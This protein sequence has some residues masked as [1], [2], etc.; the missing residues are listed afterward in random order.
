M[1]HQSRCLEYLT[2]SQQEGVGGVLYLEQRLGKTFIMIRHLKAYEE[3]TQTS[4]LIVCPNSVKDVWAYELEIE[5]END[6]VIL[7][8][9]KKQRLKLL[10]NNYKYV[11]VNYESVSKL[12][13]HLYEWS[14]VILD[15]SIYIANPK[16]QRTKYFLNSFLHI[17]FK[18]ILCGAPAPESMLQYFSQVRFV[19]KHF[20][21]HA[22]FYTYR[23]ENF[24]HVGHR[25]MPK[26][27]HKKDVYKYLRKNCFTLTRVES[28][29]GS[30]KLYQ[31]I[32][33][34]PTESQKK[35]YN[36]MFRDFE[37]D[38]IFTKYAP[39]K[40][41]YLHKISGGVNLN[42][43]EWHSYEKFHRVV[44]LLQEELKGQQ[45]LIWFKY[46]HEIKQMEN[47]LSMVPLLRNKFLMI[48]GD[49]PRTGR[50]ML[51]KAFNR[52]EY[53]IALLT[54]K[55]NRTG[56]DWSSA[57][58]AIYYSNETSNDLRSQSEDRLIHP[59]IKEPKL[60]IDICTDGSLDLDIVALLKGKKLNSEFFMSSLYEQI[61]NRGEMK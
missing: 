43:E 42:M 22:N 60:I 19:F 7:S 56:N 32:K 57:N 25:W 55:A 47:I 61:L 1:P 53:N 12:D 49:T 26:R 34:A 59:K 52:K 30:K 20:M 24:Q 28:G 17:Q 39:V 46:K 50:T 5:N 37:A 11:I 40:Y 27:G 44:E 58:T 15:E 31:I 48:T 4:A 9:T 29:L 41:L 10:E 21:L 14:S 2:E 51:R 45:V 18:Y 36:K 54:I 6:F 33:V 38:G 35:A 8:G 3:L 16:S 13:L 23:L